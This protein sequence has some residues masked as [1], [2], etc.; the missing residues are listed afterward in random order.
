MF[1]VAASIGGLKVLPLGSGA[2]AAATEAAEEVAGASAGKP[3]PFNP[4]GSKVNCVGGVC[5]FLNSVKEGRL[6]QASPNVAWNGGKTAVANQQI[7]AATG[8]SM[9][10]AQSNTLRT[11]LDR[12]FFVVYPK[13]NPNMATHVMI[14][15]NNGGKQILYDPQTG[16]RLF[17]PLMFPPFLAYPVGPL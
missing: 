6:V 3:T 4:S 1:D 2:E 7:R 11:T 14:G 16:A 12:Q 17:N 5:A 15:I 10:E 9:G 13:G 8:L